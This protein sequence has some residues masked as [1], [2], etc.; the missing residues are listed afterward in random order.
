MERELF[1]ELI[2]SVNEAIEYERGDRSKGRTMR[3]TI[4]DDEIE[5]YSMYKKLSETNKTKA[6]AYVNELLNASNK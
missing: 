1:D 4:P 3:V 6:M 5:F 2:T